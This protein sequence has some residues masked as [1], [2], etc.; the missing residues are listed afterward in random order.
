MKAVFWALVAPELIIF[1]A[2][3]QRRGAREVMIE[4]NEHAKRY[5]VEGT[6]FRSC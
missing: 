3:R 4:V 2:W 6:F 1:W 5:C